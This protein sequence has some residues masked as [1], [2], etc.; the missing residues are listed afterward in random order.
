MTGFTYNVHT[1][2]F[3]ENQYLCP[4]YRTNSTRISFLHSSDVM[5]SD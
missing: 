1:V 5:T 4:F 2:L 3:L